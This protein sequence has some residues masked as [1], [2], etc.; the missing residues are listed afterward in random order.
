MLELAD[1][2]I[3]IHHLKG[4][5]NGQ[6]D[7]LSRWPDFDQGKGDNKGVVVL[8]DTL[9]IWSARPGGKEKQDEGMINS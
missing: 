4:S 9:F 6:A 7:A 1:Y 8:P 2:D 3:E 5:A